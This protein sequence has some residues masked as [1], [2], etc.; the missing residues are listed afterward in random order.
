MS[1]TLQPLFWCSSY[2]DTKFCHEID[3]Q[4]VVT[5]WFF[6]KNC[7]NGVTQ[8]KLFIMIVKF[9]LE[10]QNTNNSEFGCY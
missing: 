10:V 2:R 3:A 4:N 1:N 5:G 6:M 9:L 7:Q 8:V